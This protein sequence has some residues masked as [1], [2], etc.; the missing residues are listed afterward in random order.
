MKLFL[1][2]LLFFLVGTF[3]LGAVLVIATWAPDQPLEA[4][5][6]RWAQPPSQFIAI[7]G[8]QV[9]LR[10]EGPRNDGLPIVLIHGTSASLHTW[11]GWAAAL[12]GQRRVIRFDLPGF[13]LTGPNRQDDY[14]VQAYVRFVT[15][16]MDQLGVQRFVLAGNSLGGQVAWATAVALPQSVAKLVLVDASGYPLESASQPPSLPLGF[17]IART[18]GLRVLT[19]YTLPRS[20]VEKS[21][22]NVYGN[23]SKVTPELVDLYRDMTLRAGNRKALGRRMDQGYTGDVAGLKTLAIPT[24]ILW[25]GQDRLIPPEFGQRFVRDI[26]GSRLVVFDDLGHV[27]HEED[28]ARTVA[29]VRAFLGL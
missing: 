10:D 3:V 11:E 9:H 14:S 8:M 2:S 16:V 12:S 7:D 27:P 13:A 4:L 19:Q 23:P 1:R 17:R 15:A 21:V 28:P 18:P 25:G 20:I 29:V 22:R 24:L 5:K 6:P 26:A